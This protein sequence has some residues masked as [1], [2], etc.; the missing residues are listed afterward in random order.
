MLLLFCELSHNILY[1]PQPNSFHASTQSKLS[2]VISLGLQLQKFAN[3]MCD[4][5]VIG[6]SSG[7]GGV[8]GRAPVIVTVMAKIHERAESW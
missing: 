6:T 7:G 5:E 3:A 2:E 4:T 1:Q 8:S